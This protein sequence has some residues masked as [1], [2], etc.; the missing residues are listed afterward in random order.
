MLDQTDVPLTGLYGRY[1]YCGRR[2]PG[3]VSYLPAVQYGRCG[4]YG[5]YVQRHPWP[6][7]W[8][9]RILRISRI[10]RTTRLRPTPST[11]FRSRTDITD[12]ADIADVNEWFIWLTNHFRPGPATTEPNQKQH[13]Q[14]LLQNLQN[15]HTQKR[16]H[17]FHCLLY[18]LS[19]STV[20]SQQRNEPMIQK[21]NKENDIRTK[22]KT[23]YG[24]VGVWGAEVQIKLFSSWQHWKRNRSAFVYNPYHTR[25][26]SH[27]QHTR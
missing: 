12:N 1:G 7:E 3:A 8:P 6:L 25:T 10:L 13:N 27:H 11:A 21:P 14:K 2:C 23:A 20:K 5:Y 17:T 15:K 19:L 16:C 22:I 18:S 9:I 24:L 4:C 26:H